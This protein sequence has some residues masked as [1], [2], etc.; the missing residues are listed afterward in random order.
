MAATTHLDD[1]WLNIAREGA[2]LGKANAQCFLGCMYHTGRGAAQDFTTQRHGFGRPQSRGTPT[3]SYSTRR[4]CWPVK[5]SRRMSTKRE[6]GSA[7]PP[8]K[9]TLK[10]SGPLEWHSKHQVMGHLNWETG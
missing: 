6:G 1:E 3:P 10:R 2:E 8:T 5:E 9:D 7:K 4:Y